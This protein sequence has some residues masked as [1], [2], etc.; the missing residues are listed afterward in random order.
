MKRTHQTFSEQEKDK[1]LREIANSRGSTRETLTQLGISKS[2][3]YGLTPWLFDSLPPDSF[4]ILIRGR[5][6]RHEP[7]MSCSSSTAYNSRFR[8]AAVRRTTPSSKRSSAT[9]RRKNSIA[10]TTDHSTRSRPA[11]GNTSRSTTRSAHIAP[12]TV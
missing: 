4:S 11:L 12:T 8:Q 7:I 6:I 1:L 5:T 2:T 9:S 10:T 3:Y